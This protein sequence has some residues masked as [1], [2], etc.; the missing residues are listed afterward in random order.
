MISPHRKIFHCFTSTG[1]AQQFSLEYFAPEIALSGPDTTRRELDSTFPS[2]L[3][4]RGGFG[5][6]YL[7]R[8]SPGS[9][10]VAMKCLHNLSISGVP[11]E[12]GCPGQSADPHNLTSEDSVSAILAFFHEFTM[13]HQLDHPNVVRLLGLHKS[14]PSM[15]LEY[16]PCGTLHSKISQ[17]R[18]NR[19]PFQLELP[20][21]LKVASDVA[22]GLNY[23][24]SLP[25]PVIHRD[26]RTPNIFLQ[27][28]DK[29]TCSDLHQIHA[30]IGDFGLACLGDIP[31]RAFLATWRVLAPEIIAAES[32]KY[33]ERS[34]IY[35]FAIACW[36]MMS[37]DSPFFEYEGIPDQTLKQQI[38]KDHLRPTIPAHT[39]QQF[40]DLIT[41]CWQGDPQQ[42]PSA[43]LLSNLMWINE[44][45]FQVRDITQYLPNS[46]TSSESGG[47]P[48][49]LSYHLPAN[50]FPNSL[51]ESP[52]HLLL[53]TEADKMSGN[54]FWA[55]FKV[56]SA[57]NSFL[58][59]YHCSMLDP[60]D[61]AVMPLQL[62][63]YNLPMEVS[64]SISV[65]GAITPESVW[66]GFRDGTIL[67]TQLSCPGDITPTCPYRQPHA[68][69]M[70]IKIE[71]LCSGFCYSLDCSGTIVLWKDKSPTTTIS[72]D[73]FVPLTQIIGLSLWCCT[74]DTL[75]L[76]GFDT[77][78]AQSTQ[79]RDQSAK[80][81]I[82]KIVLKSQSSIVDFIDTAFNTVW[83]LDRY[84]N[85]SVLSH[86]GVLENVFRAGRGAI[87][88]AATSPSKEFVLSIGE[89]QVTLWSCQNPSPLQT[90]SL[91]SPHALVRSWIEVIV[92]PSPVQI[93]E[94][95]GLTISVWSAQE[96]SEKSSDSSER[97]VPELDF[98][99]Y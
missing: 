36:E 31:T 32:K 2:Q 42:R 93:L 95:S 33:D 75:L 54:S 91:S 35:S 53:I 85:I 37:W 92:L 99:D 60:V 20:F 17:D 24:H 82:S 7:C 15:L 86:L 12:H 9:R 55:A 10:L 51:Q 70:L 58:R 81:T 46:A 97:L 45:G 76:I 78:L 49:R 28:L 13:M 67:F 48:H 40:K 4:G 27:S 89:K 63:K 39:P 64:T 57:D 84:E 65:L 59:L 43:K 14:S 29:T 98:D 16:V 88:L 94:L 72:L 79:K 73:E 56:K 22:K 80:P 87:R 62:L 25:T 18:E 69:H 6:V 30:K 8:L 1:N 5:E 71:S 61:D 41:A 23:L 11:V 47:L 83:C 77:I 52:T 26:L 44:N 66:L 3:L 38:I 34:D 74:T 21:Y 68:G 50:V 96:E 19:I 90:I